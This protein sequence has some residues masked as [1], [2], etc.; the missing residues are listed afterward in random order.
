[1]KRNEITVF[2]FCKPDEIIKNSFYST[3]VTKNDGIQSFIL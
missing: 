3:S 1:M 2:I